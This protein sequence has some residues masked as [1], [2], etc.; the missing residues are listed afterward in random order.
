MKTIKIFAV[1]VLL[2]YGLPGWAQEP[3]EETPEYGWKNQIIGTFNLTQ[4]SFDN[5][6]QGGENTFAGQLQL[7]TNFVLQ[8]ERFN[9]SNMAKFTYGMAKVGENEARKSA[10]EIRLESVYTRNVSW[11]VSPFVAATAATQFTSG[12]EYD[13]DT[14]TKVS[15]FLD[16]GYFTQSVGFAYVPNEE[17]RTRIG[18]TLKETITNDFSAP[19][20]DDPNTVAVEK[21]KVEPGVSSVTDF[22]KTLHENILYVGRLDLFS[23]FKAFDR[24]DVLWE[25]HVTMKVTKL[26]AVGFN[27]D[28]FYDKDI[29]NKRQIRQVLAIGLTYSFL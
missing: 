6:T 21:T 25:N 18:A 10:D 1:V 22:Q 29:S 7:K 3:A 15:K 27:V 19:Y 11:I 2:F 4:A 5:W 13:G 16:P 17:I 26:I 28:L 14:K 8:Q 9:W 12:F 24:V 23:D 20:A